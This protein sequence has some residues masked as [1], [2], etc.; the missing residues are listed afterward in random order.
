MTGVGIGRFTAASTAYHERAAGRSIP[1]DNAQNFWRHTLAEQGLLGL[2]PILWLTVLTLR[3]FAARSPTH[4][5]LVMKVM[6]GS[7]GVALLFGYPVQDAAIAVT[8]GT[9]VAAVG[10]TRADARQAG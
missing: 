5:D 4:P 1:P 2:L 10:R 6:L 8:V 7:I 9:L 3:S